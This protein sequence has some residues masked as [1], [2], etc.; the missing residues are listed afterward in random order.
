MQSHRPHLGGP[1]GVQITQHVLNDFFAFRFTGKDPRYALLVS[2]GL[3]GHCGIYNVFCERHAE[4]GVD[5]WAYDAPG[6]GR[7]TMTRGRGE[8][9]LSEWVEACVA[10]AEHIQQT[11][12][13]PVIVL[14]S[15]LGVAAS[16]SALGSKAVRGAVLMGAAA[17]PCSPGGLAPDNPLRGPEMDNFEARY[18]RTLRLDIGRLIN[19]DEDYG[20]SGAAE[21]K[22]L[23]PF[24]TWHY[25][26]AS[27]RSLFTYT[28]P[29]T[30]ERNTKPILFAVGENDAITSVETVRGCA[31]SI[32][33][34]V[35]VEV[36]AGAGHQLM[37]FDTDRFSNLIES[38]VPGALEPR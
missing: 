29:I 14:G 26:F 38:W 31:A 28:P 19:F 9:R 4:R 32:A 11:T 33:G 30:P 1:N 3:G 25:D 20:Y 7:S 23:D 15:S 21:Q 5:V 10:W 24:N 17:V 34:P 16:F 36:L 6:H 18:G 12:G 13:L 37:L 27:W 8:F 22:R 2:H 35:R